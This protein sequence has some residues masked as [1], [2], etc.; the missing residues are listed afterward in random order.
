MLIDDNKFINEINEELKLERMR[1][2]NARFGLPLIMALVALMILIGGWSIYSYVK[3]NRKEK[4]G[5]AFT[6]AL[7][8]ADAAD[9]ADTGN[10][11]QALANLDKVQASNI[12]N[13]ANLAL[14]RKATLLQKHGDVARAKQDLSIVLHDANAPI[15]LQDV[16]RLKLSYLLIDEGDLKALTQMVSPFDKDDNPFQLLSWEALGLAYLKHNDIKQAANYFNKILNRDKSSSDIAQRAR[17]VLA[18]MSSH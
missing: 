8:A 15:M 9:A 3:Q 16:A 12:A 7:L 1:S 10:F 14:L 11:T 13:Y 6:A 5:D 17:L 4:I 18:T 2:L